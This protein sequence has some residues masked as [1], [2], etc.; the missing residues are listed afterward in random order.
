MSVYSPSSRG[1]L[2][3]ARH[4]LRPCAGARVCAWAPASG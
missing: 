2:P 3:D 1:A 4:S